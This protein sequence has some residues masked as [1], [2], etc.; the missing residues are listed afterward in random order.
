MSINLGLQCQF[1]KTLRLPFSKV[2]SDPVQSVIQVLT[3][4]AYSALAI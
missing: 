2:E 4:L 3:K 1:C